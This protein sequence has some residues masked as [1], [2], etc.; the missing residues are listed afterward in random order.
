MHPPSLPRRSTPHSTLQSSCRGS[1]SGRQRSFAKACAG[2][3]GTRGAE[4]GA[5]QG[6]GRG[7]NVCVLLISWVP[8]VSP[9]ASP[10]VI[11]AAALSAPGGR[12]SHSVQLRY[13]AEQTVRAAEQKSAQRLA[14]R[15]VRSRPRR[16]PTL[17]HVTACVG[18]A[19]KTCEVHSQARPSPRC[20]SARARV[21]VWRRWWWREAPL[22][23]RI[24]RH[25]QH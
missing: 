20:V 17:A 1:C 22:I 25:S 19:Q 5:R 12:D 2:G 24:A 4:R 14:V 3:R 15:P 21:C 18:I 9:L 7:G 6:Q 13:A 10:Q 8:L 16:P 11:P 23:P